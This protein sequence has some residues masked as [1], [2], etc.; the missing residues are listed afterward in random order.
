MKVS[1]TIRKVGGLFF[2]MDSPTE[3]MPS[4]TPFQADDPLVTGSASTPPPKTVTKTAEQIVREQPGPNLD[5]IKPT[6]KQETP[7]MPVLNAD[8]TVNFPAIY[9][10]ANLPTVPF[11][12]ENVLELLASFPADLP[13]ESKRATLKITLGAMAQTNG[14]SSEQVVADASRKLA[15]L[16]SYAE[17][18]HKQAEEY[19]AL[20]TSEIE[21][22]QAQIE[23]RKKGI[24]AAQAKSESMTAACEKETDRLDDVLEFF[25]LD[26]P[27]SKFAQ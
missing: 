12:A 2:E 25:S 21:R 19:V 7:A 4:T 16:A 5:E 13:V 15:A 22:L 8:G 17:S 27:P 1:D 6:V 9:Q 3:A 14:A 10:M 24:V 26:K 23:D 11:T 20:A 18:F